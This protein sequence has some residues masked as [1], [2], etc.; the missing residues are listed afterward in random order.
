MLNYCNNT[1][2]EKINIKRRVYESLAVRFVIGRY[3]RENIGFMWTVVEP[4]MLCV[5][6]MMIWSATKGSSYHGVNI[7]A[8]VYTGYMPLTLWRHQ[9]GYMINIGKHTKFLTIFREITILDS[10]ICRL[11]LEFISVTASAIIVFFV[12]YAV[13]II[14]APKDTPT[15]LEG[16]LIMTLIGSSFGVLFAALSELSD[17]VERINPPVQYF[18][19]PFSGCFFMVD[20]LPDTARNYILYVPIVHAYEIMRKGYYGEGILTYGN[21]SY[22]IIFAIVTAGLG[23]FLFELV[24]DKIDS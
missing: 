14:D 23:L 7:V 6:V 15:L 10:I 13:G 1:F 18:L 24:K 5:G 22:A 4:M 9:T 16:W 11:S 3:G 20:W 12:L 19:I 21:G 8:F 17:I 2:L